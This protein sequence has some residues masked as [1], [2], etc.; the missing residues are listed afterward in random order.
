MGEFAITREFILAA[1]CGRSVLTGEDV[2]YTERYL[3]DVK[4]VLVIRVILFALEATIS[5]CT[6]SRKGI[7]FTSSYDMINCTK[8]EIVYKDGMPYLMYK[9]K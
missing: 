8:P 4:N 3:P 2:A 5:I 1:V 7:I 6:S 9:F